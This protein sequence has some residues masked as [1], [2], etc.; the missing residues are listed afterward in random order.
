M[1]R[2]AVL[3][4]LVFATLTAAAQAPISG[5]SYRPALGASS[6][7]AQAEDEFL[8]R[9]LK[10]GAE[11][12]EQQINCEVVQSYT[13]KAWDGRTLTKTP[14]SYYVRVKKGQ[15]LF[16]KIDRDGTIA[17]PIERPEYQAIKIYSIAGWYTAP[18]DIFRKG[19]FSYKR[20]IN[21][22]IL[23]DFTVTRSFSLTRNYTRVTV[24]VTGE[25]EFDK[26]GLLRRIYI[27]YTMEPGEMARH[28]F[29]SS[30]EET[31]FDN[32]P[33]FE[34]VQPVPVR[35]WAKMATTYGDKVIIEATYKD[36]KRF[37]TDVVFSEVLE[38]VKST[39]RRRIDG[40]LIT[41]TENQ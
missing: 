37:D 38:E 11:L 33:G 34:E 30:E 22:R 17:P 27:R 19:Q 28:K 15:E 32:P 4:I 18:S 24:D 36:Y 35:F 3:A 20:E 12:L 5:V 39:V 16:H 29:K 21:K 7:C 14:D 2:I 23:Y 40:R 6:E 8:C 25:I 1:K 9:A 41:I 10:K 13:Q 31:I 26:A